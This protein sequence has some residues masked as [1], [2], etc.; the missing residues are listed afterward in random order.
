M[1]VRLRRQ[2]N[3]AD[4]TPL[5]GATVTIFE[6]GQT[7]AV[8]TLTSDANGIIETTLPDDQSTRTNVKYDMRVD[9]SGNRWWTRADDRAQIDGLDVKGY[10]R[11][12]KYTTT[13]RDLSLI[14]I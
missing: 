2:I 5:A 13:E 14:H 1:S 8:E 6:V 7:E 9:F 10:F 3:N 12:P 11:L 4:G